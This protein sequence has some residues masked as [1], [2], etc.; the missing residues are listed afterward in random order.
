M[1]SAKSAQTCICLIDKALSLKTFHKSTQNTLICSGFSSNSLTSKLNIRLLLH[2]LFWLVFAYLSSSFL[3]G[4]VPLGQ[5]V[6]R[7]LIVASAN[8]VLVY[9]NMF[10]LVPRWFQKGQYGIYVLVAFLFS[11]P[12]ML[13][14]WKL[15]PLVMTGV[16]FSRIFPTQVY[17]VIL[18]SSSLAMLVFSLGYTLAENYFTAEAERNKVEKS[19]LEAETNFLRAQI[20]PHFLFNTLN[21]LYTLALLKS[22]KA[23]DAILKLSQLMRFMLYD[24]E[25]RQIPLEKEIQY[26][27]DFI[28]LELLRFEEEKEVRFEVQSDLGKIQLA[29]LLLIPLVENCFKYSDLAYSKMAYVYLN[30]HR[31]EN[32]WLTFK[33]R[34]SIDPKRKSTQM[35]GGIGLSNLKQRLAILYTNRH[36]LEIQ[37]TENEFLVTLSLKI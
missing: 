27:R 3:V 25:Q 6:L 18:V 10:V 14:R 7:L 2:G 13:M 37:S 15:E 23:P 20:N 30:L 22:D 1:L 17:P 9:G 26:V 12:I 33:A 31:D 34:N 36:Y 21:N 16:S 8:V 29:P 5:I 4:I 24:T 28:D 19:R 35:Q 11:L 32:G